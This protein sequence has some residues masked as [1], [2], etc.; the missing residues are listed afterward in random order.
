[1]KITLV[2][3]MGS[4]KSTVAKKLSE[5]LG[6]DWVDIDREVERE[7]GIP[8]PDIF[9]RFGEDFFR[10]KEREKLKEILSRE[11]DLVISTGGGLPAYRDSMK[12][13]NN[14]SFSVYLECPFDVLWKRI[15]GD[16]NRP[17]VKLGFERVKELFERRLPYYEMA[18]LK[19]RTDNIS[20]DETVD[21][22]IDALRGNTSRQP[23]G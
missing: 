1:M 5:R 22:I 21:R 6:V 4:G 15:S 18:R 3:F 14:R 7:V 16:G 13:I 9:K 2:G 23:R 17:L 8:I 11:E 20:P 10:R 12:L 19:V